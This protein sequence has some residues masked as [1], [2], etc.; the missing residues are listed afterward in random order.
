[1]YT[2]RPEIGLDLS[3][4]YRVLKLS[5][6]PIVTTWLNTRLQDVASPV[7]EQ[8]IFFHDYSVLT[9]VV[10]VFLW[11][12]ICPDAEVASGVVN[13]DDKGINVCVL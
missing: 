7:L 11:P 4:T 6:E 12:V 9:C 10:D 13:A 1:M 2:V 5:L 8:L 3:S